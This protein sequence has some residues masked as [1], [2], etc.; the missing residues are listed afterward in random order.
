MHIIKYAPTKSDASTPTATTTSRLYGVSISNE[1]SWSRVPL[2]AYPVNA[3]ALCCTPSI[4]T[5]MLCIREYTRRAVNVIGNARFADSA[6]SGAAP[7]S[8][9]SKRLI[10]M[11]QRRQRQRKIYS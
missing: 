10:M 11:S 6:P 9:Q 2:C 4:D 3:L 7:W 8:L 1:K 5:V